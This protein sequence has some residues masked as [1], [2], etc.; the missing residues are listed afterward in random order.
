MKALG[1]VGGIAAAALV[2][3]CADSARPAAPATVAPPPARMTGVE[4]LMGLN[5]AALTQMFGAPDADMREGAARKLQFQS[6]VCVLDTYLYPAHGKEPQVTYVDA[7]Q[8]DGS[9][10]DRASCAAALE[11]RRGG[12]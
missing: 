3:G 2:S 6:G 8:T 4:R 10:I 11:R 1:M 5:A 12:K 9:P 7:R